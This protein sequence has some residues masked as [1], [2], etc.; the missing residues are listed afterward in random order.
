MKRCLVVIPAYNEE[1]ALP[2]VFDQLASA[3]P[4]YD[5]VVVDDGSTDDTVAVA[6]SSG[7]PC[8]RLPFNLGVGGAV[9]TGLRYAVRERYDRAVVFDGDGQHDAGMIKVLMDALDAGAD[10]AVGSRFADPEVGYEVGAVRRRAMGVL[11]RLVKLSTGQ[12]FT[13]STSGFRAFDGQ[14]LADVAA[15]YPVDYLSDT[16]EVLVEAC[17]RGHTV[18]EVPITMHP[19]RTGVPS[20]RDLWLPYHFTRVV[21]A[22]VASAWRRSAPPRT[23]ASA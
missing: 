10:V 12:V 23:K 21:L 1:A 2:R 11:N 20:A 3:V 6:R 4:A 18:V 19:R 5:P 15:F 8:L 13:D 7:V 22:L 9:R 17:R 16:V 14:A